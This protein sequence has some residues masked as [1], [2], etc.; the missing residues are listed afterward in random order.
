MCRWIGHSGGVAVTWCCMLLQDVR[1]E[2]VQAMQSLTK[3]PAVAL[4]LP[5]PLSADAQEALDDIKQAG[6]E[7]R[8]HGVCVCVC[9]RCAR[10]E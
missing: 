4:M 3:V 7:Q 8:K 2:C 5:M 1:A 10:C 9:A 6:D